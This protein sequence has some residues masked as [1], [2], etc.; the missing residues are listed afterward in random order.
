MVAYWLLSWYSSKYSHKA[1]DRIH[2][3]LLVECR[4]WTDFIGTMLWHLSEG[5]TERAA[6]KGVERGRQGSDGYWIKLVGIV[7]KKN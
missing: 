4:R 5:G 7:V 2:I 3:A 6:K 1:D